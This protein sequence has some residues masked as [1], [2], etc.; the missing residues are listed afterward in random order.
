MLIDVKSKGESR[1]GN[2]LPALPAGTG[3]LWGCRGCESRIFLCTRFV[4]HYK[5]LIKMHKIY[6]KKYLFYIV[7]FLL[8]ILNSNNIIAQNDV[9][10][11]TYMFNKLAFN[12]AYAGSHEVLTLSAH[13]RNQWAGLDGAPQTFSFAAHTPF[14]DRRCGAGLSII[15]DKIGLVNN[16]YIDLSYNYKIGINKITTLNIGL[17]AQLYHSRMDWGDADPLDTTDADL[18][19]DDVRQFNPN[20][21]LGLYLQNPNYYLGISAPKLLKTSI[22]DKKA[23]AEIRGAVLQS[24]YLMGGFTKR[25]NGKIEIQPGALISFNPNAPFELDLNFN[26]IFLEKMLVGLSYRL[27]DSFDAILQFRINKNLK[28][29]VAFDLTTSELRAHSP[30]SFE[31]M[32]EYYFHKKEVMVDNPRFF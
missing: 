2:P 14:L 7:L 11:T 4:I 10:Y 3:R 32:L 29:A 31:L 24:Y 25:L 1:Y 17:D 28:V 18:L 21:G 13:Y 6:L 12:P 5:I 27:Q 9:H 20:F 16:L 15:S 19:S 30:G 23:V 26:I 22:Y 8:V